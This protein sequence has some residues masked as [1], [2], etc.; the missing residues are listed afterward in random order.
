MQCFVL[1]EKATH[2]ESTE[3]FSQCECSLHICVR[4][5][6]WEQHVSTAVRPV[7]PNDIDSSKMWP[8]WTR[9]DCQAKIH[10]ISTCSKRNLRSKQ[11]HR[12]NFER[13][14]EQGT[15]NDR[16]PITKHVWYAGLEFGCANHCSWT[17]GK[18]RPLEI[19]RKFLLQ[20]FCRWWKIRANSSF[21]TRFG[22]SMDTRP[23][24]NVTIR[25]ASCDIGIQFG[26]LVLEFVACFMYMFQGFPSKRRPVTPDSR[27]GFGVSATIGRSPMSKVEKVNGFR[28][29]INL[30]IGRWEL[31]PSMSIRFLITCCLSLFS[32]SLCSFSNS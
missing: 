12:A 10:S 1:S 32:I 29:E 14:H 4:P 8:V 25:T 17:T 24:R 23:L 6:C 5:E 22:M 31:L 27:M 9:Y 21:S 28:A 16:T 20:P 15:D 19:T 11:L 26:S 30:K 2:K 13:R 3:I 7:G 18:A